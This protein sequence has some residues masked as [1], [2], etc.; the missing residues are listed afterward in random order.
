MELGLVR[1]QVGVGE[2]SVFSKR[3]KVQAKGS[4]TA[5]QSPLDIT[6][7]PCASPTHPR[8]LLN[9]P[10]HV[11]PALLHVALDAARQAHVVV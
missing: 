9:H 7:Q 6:Q 4:R 10:R 2:N 8:V 5:H 11:A 3:S 1:I